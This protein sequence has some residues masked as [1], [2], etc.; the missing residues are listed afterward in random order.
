MQ[1]NIVKNNKYISEENTFSGKQ[2]SKN[3][4][5]IPNSKEE[6]KK[7]SSSNNVH[8]KKTIIKKKPTKSAANSPASLKT[9]SLSQSD[10]AAYKIPK[11]IQE[12]S[13]LKLNLAQETNY[14][15]LKTP[16]S[17][18]QKAEK[19]EK[20]I[21]FE[22]K[23]II[24]MNDILRGL[25]EKEEE[26]EKQLPSLKKLYISGIIERE[27]YDFLVQSVVA[28]IKELDKKIDYEIEIQKIKK[29]KEN[30]EESITQ[31]LLKGEL[32]EKAQHA[33]TT[34]EHLYNDGII[35]Q[36]TYINGRNQIMLRERKVKELMDKIEDIL[37]NY[38]NESKERTTEKVDINYT[39]VE[40]KI[41]KRK[42]S[43]WMILKKSLKK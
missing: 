41:N 20:P 10:V 6:N 38:V 32:R 9:S 36:K 33:L 23:Q 11:T 40:E 42:D 29:C 31:A 12:E 26:L 15:N 8:I 37:D 22:K 16:E 18:N 1:E 30:I 21:E 25:K 17:Y 35:S 43:L 19:Y 24:E 5:N 14:T 34:L 39:D 2:K 4:T 13:P 3:N 27:E 28:K 7:E